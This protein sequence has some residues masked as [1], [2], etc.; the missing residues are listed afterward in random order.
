MFE[1]YDLAENVQY[2]EDSNGDVHELL[3]LEKPFVTKTQ[4]PQ[5]AANEYLDA[6]G[7]FYK[8]TADQRKNAGLQPERDMIEAD[9]EYRFLEEKTMFD[10][11]TVTYQQTY[12][13]LP[14]RNAGLSIHMKRNPLRVMSSQLTAE[15]TIKVEKPS[16][17]S[18]KKFV[19]IDPKLLATLLGLENPELLR[20]QFSRLI[21]YKYEKEERMQVGP[22]EPEKEPFTHVPP[23]LPLP[24]FPDS[25]VDGRYYVAAE[26]TFLYPLASGQEVAWVAIIEVETD[27][28]LYLRAFIDSVDGQVFVTDPITATGNTSITP[29]SNSGTLNMFRTSVRLPG[30]SSYAIR[31]T[32]SLRGNLIEISD[33]EVPTVTPPTQPYGSN[34]DYDSRTNNFAAVNAYYHCDRFFRLVESLGFDL[35]SYFDRTSFPLPV[36]HRGNYV[37]DAGTV[38]TNGV[39]AQCIGDGMGGIRSTDYMLADLADIT[40][41][42]GIAADWRVVLHELGGHGILYEHIN[43][44]NFRFA[45]SAGDSFAAILNDPGTQAPDRFVTFPWVNIGRRHDRRVADGWGWSGQI[46]LNPFNASLDRGG[47]RT[48]QIL[49]T[50]LFKIYRSIGGDSTSVNLQRFAARF[51][52]YLLLRAV[53]TLTPATTPANASNFATTL[54]SV[55]ADDW[56]SEGHAGG[57]YGKV[58]RWAFE[59][60]GLYQASGTPTPNNNEGLPP[61]VDVYIDDGR[62]G[63]YPFQANYWSCQSIWNSRSPGGTTHEEP[64]VGVTNYAYVKIKNRGTQTATNVE[65]R[66]FHCRPSAGLVW[67]ND[68]Q[69]MVTPRL[70]APD[71]PPSSTMEITVGPFEWVPSQPEHECMLMI[72]SASGDPS[73]TNNITAGDSIPDWRL[74]P[75]DNNIGQRNVAPVP[76]RMGSGLA[77]AFEKR[78]F[79]VSNPHSQKARMNLVAI[80]PALL[81]ERGWELVFLNAGEGSFSLEP[82]QWKEVIMSLKAGKDFSKEETAIVPAEERF[83]HIEAYA[84][85]ILVGGMSYMLDPEM[86]TSPSQKSA[87][88]K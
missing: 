15:P 8:I 67:P 73:N 66:G 32:N 30:I 56:T 45:H 41:P 72:V 23:T 59:R 31:L 14:V 58:I 48:E 40:N 6:Y 84:D 28:V 53:G 83:I 4:L 7:K 65:V 78:V 18:A 81:S 35:E 19:Q 74:V 21:I 3:H 55:D 1:N 16:P 25:I 44:A 50:T 2:I 62:R 17:E 24:P 38:I 29:A 82:S 11:T 61:P 43:F 70:S 68:W 77:E 79:W 10:S 49:S 39:N 52:T 87:D 47:Y 86:E 42:I 60:Q 75:H 20:V 12:F 34:F 26:I 71:V 27:A 69:P 9:I 85:D 33:F 80:L 22:D 51:V 57:A 36:D 13:G 88:N 64:I 46:A 63:E 76:A 37:N 5:L 54:I